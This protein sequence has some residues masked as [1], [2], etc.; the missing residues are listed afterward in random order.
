[1]MTA[2]PPPRSSPA[3]RRFVA[4]AFGQPQDV[5]EGVCFGFVWKKASPAEGGTEGRAMDGD[6]GLEAR[7]LVVAEEDL[8]V[9][10]LG[11]LIEY[12][13]GTDLL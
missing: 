2:L 1:M 9:P 13:Q 12:D 5:L 11:Y 7:Y 8:F 3:A 10:L 6:D 4:H